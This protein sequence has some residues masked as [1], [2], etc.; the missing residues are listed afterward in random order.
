[1]TMSFG[2]DHYVP[3]LK[4]KR[5]EA[6]AMALLDASVR[7]ALTPLFEVVELGGDDDDD[8]DA[9]D[10]QD[11]LGQHIERAAGYLT[12]VVEKGKVKQCFLECRSISSGGSAAVRALFER[13]NGLDAW[14]VPV[15]G[16]S[17][18]DDG[19]VELARE[20]GSGIAI[21]LTRD[22]LRA[23]RVKR[24]LLSW[25]K[26]HALSP[27]SVDV[28]MDLGAVADMV[29]EGVEAEADRF[30]AALPTPRAWRT[31]TMSAVAFSIG[32]VE[33]NSNVYKERLDWRAW[34]E[35]AHA[36]RSSLLRLPTF[37]DGG[38]QHPRGVENIP[39]QILNNFA[40]TVRYA[41]EDDWLVIKGVGRQA[42][43]HK[44][45]FP[46]MAS[47]LINNPRFMGAS[48]CKGCAD[49]ERAAQGK[50]NL[51]GQEVWLRLGA[52]HHLTLAVAQLAALP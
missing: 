33:T 2:S 36:G 35:H 27:E 3:V 50:P 51:G 12:E 15:T 4:L 9:N 21:R 46:A 52:I 41:T 43:P 10:A 13:I 47:Q 25:V 28:I 11:T 45:Q 39:P 26:T 29:A 34:R 22:D 1:M 44:D 37:S 5:A 32:G 42:S 17:R 14:C 24:E 7:A 16:M 18:P 20:S 23:G 49:A 31:L 38:I 6:K 8:D 30:L 19:T 48:H 40:P